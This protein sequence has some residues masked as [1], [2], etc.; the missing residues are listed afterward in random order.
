MQPLSVQNQSLLPGALATPVLTGVTSMARAVRALIAA[1]HRRAT[2]ILRITPALLVM[3]GISFGCARAALSQGSPAAT[4]T[5]VISP[6]AGVYSG[7]QTVTITD[8]TPGANIYYTLNGSL[9]TTGSAQYSGSITVSTSETV[10]AM[11]I[12]S[13]GNAQSAT[14]VAQYIIQGAPSSFIYSIA[15]NGH[16]GYSGD[17]GAATL[18]QVN[19]VSKA[20]L[21]GAG[22]LYIADRANNRVRKVAAGTGVITT[23]AGNGTAGYS[24]DNG[25]A[26]DAEVS[27]AGLAL[28]SAGNLFIADESNSVVR[29][30]AAAT[31]VITTFAGNGKAGYS[32]DT[33]AATSAE[34]SQPSAIAVD[35]NGN[36]YIAENGNARIRK[37]TA[38]AGIITTVAGNGTNGYS[39]NGGLAINAA[40]NRPSGLALDGAGNLYV[41]DTYNNVIRKVTASSGLITA[42]AGNGFGA[43]QFFGGYSGDGG[44]ATNAELNRPEDVAV[45]VAGNLYIADSYNQVIRK[46]TAS[47][48][49]ITTFAGNGSDCNAVS[50]DG[51]PATSAGL[52]YPPGV[53]VDG[54]G[55]L[56]IADNYQ[57]VREVTVAGN[58]PTAVTTAPVFSVSGGTYPDPESVT[59][60]DSTPGASIYMTMD[61]STPNG[62]SEGNNGPIDVSGTVTIKAIAIAP[63][64]LQSAAVTEAYTITAPPSSVISTAAGSGI[65]GFSG[66]GSAATSAEVGDPKGVA[67]DGNGNLYFTDSTNNVVWMVSAGTGAIS[68]AAGNGM[69]GYSGDA[70]L[71]TSAKL[72][73]PS[74]I[75]S[76]K[77]GNLYIADSDNAAVRR[78][79]AKTKV[80]TTY[81]GDG[82][83]GYSG[84]S[85]AATAAEL[86]N[87]DGVA[88]DSAGNVYVADAGNG[89][90]RKILATTG[91]ITTIA[92]N[93]TAVYS[94]DGGL[95]TSAGFG[96]INGI[97]FDGANN[98][99]I[100]DGSG[101]IREVEASTGTITTVAGNG[102]WGYS[103]DGGPA[104]SAEIADNNVEIDS[105]G[106]IYI[107]DGGEAVREVWG[108][109]AVITTVAG[110]GFFG[111]YGDGLSATV[112]EIDGP[113]GIA[114]D[115]KGDLYIADSGN[116]RIREVTFTGPAAAPVFSLASGSYLGA[117]TLSMT[118]ITPGA[119]IYYT[120]NGTTPTTGSAKYSSSIMVSE[121]ET[122][123]AIAV[124]TGHAQSAVSTSTYTI[125]P[126]PLSPFG[127]L[128]Q[129][130]DGLTRSTTVSQADSLFVSGWV[131]DATD[132]APLGNVKVYID[133][134]L[135]GTPTLGV[136]RPD[137]AADLGNS[138]FT[139]SGYQLY[140]SAA[141]F[142]A[143]THAITVVAIDSGG[144][145]TT[146]GPLSITVTA[147]A[148]PIG[149]LE[150]AVDSVTGSTTV[151]QTDS[152][153]VSGWVADATDGAPLKNVKVYIDGNLAGT[154]ILGIARPDVAAALNNP[155]YLDSGYQFYYS[156]A[157]LSPGA[158]AVTVVAIDSGGRSTTFGPLTITVTGSSLPPPFGNLEVA[159]DS[160]TRSTTVS[161]SDSVY[162]A[163]W[164]ADA[165]DGAPLKNVKV[166]IDGNLVGTPILGIARPDVA[167]AYNSAAY[168]N[169]GYAFY[170]SA[171]TLSPGTHAVTVVA[172]DSGGRS[173]TL[174]PLSITVTSAAPPPPPPF[175][176]LEVAEDSVTGSTTV[177][178]SD[179]V[180]VAGWVADA[181]D[182][183]PLKNVEVYV[184]GNLIGTPT[185]GIARPD[186]ATALNNPA[187]LDSGYQFYYAAAAFF[188]STHTVTVVAIDSGGRSTT[189][190][191]LTITV[192]P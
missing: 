52:C 101:R 132:G 169:S 141:A 161:Q 121:T 172:I 113:M 97:A 159:E 74:G 34:L 138:A 54:A 85:G 45:D 35:S 41:A 139:N 88:L 163:G 58:P 133:G 49:I 15:G 155:A 166:Y 184:D 181:T 124:A 123:E 136:A 160:S 131:A 4:A 93:G 24:G 16:F 120:T 90:V 12:A 55:N 6:G 83:V 61:G 82:T 165:A 10:V 144:R 60:T 185:L 1:G 40:M 42:V 109:P 20:I 188:P 168:L 96:N 130:V 79:D 29:E 126:L 86:S 118:D 100:A 37:V 72:N 191:P 150:Q 192:V 189:F 71:A 7:T 171:A 92:G 135:L 62:A 110:N 94:G 112:A 143:G 43:G 177:S 56:Y 87:P 78:V 114:F 31:G 106:N 151:P 108:S 65:N 107:S 140:Q 67:L 125:T 173:T 182:G 99:Y 154:P 119:V 117:R 104:T 73:N 14:A 122:L 75:A 5:P 27:P 13:P 9:P 68:I 19:G 164:V 11:A 145:S 33:G 178:Q 175:G 170:Y 17:G 111:Y 25:P 179:S 2:L 48:G 18:A 116:Y 187:Y 8:T 38:P 137:V 142:S 44:S 77:A 174:G 147:P 95:A 91:V 128:E 134:N 81:A 46:V 98:L 176:N 149:N 129:A 39:G 66:A 63:G 186:V 32:G 148:P 3:L 115:G 162:V 84:D 80:I 89:V 59:I 21:D 180:Y 70:G 105:A 69:P 22:N 156:A 26:V 57:R 158:H 167:A 190:G 157:T 47:N 76:D 23:Y 153:F 152:V 102:D 183:A 127:N 51:G 30:V 146:F 53:S 103:G 28:D 50:G 36:L 64:N